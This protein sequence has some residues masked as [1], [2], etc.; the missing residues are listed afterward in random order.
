[1]TRALK[2]RRASR[3]SAGT[4]TSVSGG[5]SDAGEQQPSRAGSDIS[6]QQAVEGD[7]SD[8]DDLYS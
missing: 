5:Q 4:G 7:E 2:E 6:S 8:E 1:M 3:G